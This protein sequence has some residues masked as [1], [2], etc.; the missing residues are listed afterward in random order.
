[1]P[2]LG[3]NIQI[4]PSA[5]VDSGAQI[6]D[7]TKIWHFV[8]VT[9]AAKIGSDCV[10][11]HSCFIDGTIGDRVHISNF[12]SIYQGCEIGDDTFIG[13][14]V[15]FANVTIPKVHRPIDRNEYRKTIVGKNC[16]IEQNASILPGANIA[17]D[18]IVGMG[19]V[20]CEDLPARVMVTGNPARIAIKSLKRM[21][22]I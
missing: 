6:G 21:S 3:N 11:G 16:T 1:M 20:V 5:I 9:S 10:I 8:H 22:G 13:N 18:T 7:N 2:L 12:V 14:G 17:H 4:H 19:S 15:S